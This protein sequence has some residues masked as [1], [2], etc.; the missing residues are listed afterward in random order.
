MDFTENLLKEKKTFF[1]FMK[2]KYPVYYRSNL[3]LRD[4]EYAILI[5]YRKKN[6]NLNYS[7]ISEITRALINSMV[8]RGELKK[9]TDNAYLF[10]ADFLKEEKAVEEND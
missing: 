10:E 2:E 6:I 1:N 3:F 9:I 5:Y 8:E 4:I 7:Q